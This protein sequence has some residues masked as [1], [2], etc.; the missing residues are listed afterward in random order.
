MADWYNLRLEVTGLPADLQTF[1]KAAGALRGRID[2]SR[3]AIF[4]AAMEYGETYDLEAEQPV[5]FHDRWTT[6]R[7]RLQ[8]RNTATSKTYGR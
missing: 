6:A 4:T 8:G 2:T 1:R 7:Y 3:S 5:G